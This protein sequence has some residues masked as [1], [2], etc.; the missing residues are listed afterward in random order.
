MIL[1]SYIERF[2]NKYVASSSGGRNAHLGICGNLG[3]RRAYHDAF[4]IDLGVE[5]KTVKRATYDV[6]PDFS[7]KLE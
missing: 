5:A 3:F 6:A 4:A 1:L 2:V 7:S